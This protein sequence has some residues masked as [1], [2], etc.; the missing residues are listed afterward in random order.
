MRIDSSLILPAF[1]IDFVHF[2]ENCRNVVG[3]F[4]AWIMRLEFAVVTDPP[5][6]VPG[7]VLLLI[8]VRQTLPGDLFAQSDPFEHGAVA[9]AAPTNIIDFSNSG[10][11]EKLIERL[12]QIAAVDGIADLLAFVPENRVR[13]AGHDAAHQIAQKPVQLGGGVLRSG[14]RSPPEAG[15]AQAEVPSILLNENI[16]RDFRR[17]E[18]AVQA[19]VDRHILSD[20]RLVR[21]PRRDLIAQLPLHQRQAVGG[22]PINF[23]GRGENKDCLGAVLPGRFQKIERP[24]GVYIKIGERLPGRPVMRWLRRRVNNQGDIFAVAG[25]DRLDRVPVPDIGCE[26]RVACAQ[27]GLEV[28]DIPGRAGFRAEEDLTHIVVYP[29]DIQPRL[30]EMQRRFRTDQSG[31][32]GDNCNAHSVFLF[33]VLSC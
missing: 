7:P 24:G 21:M 4:P 13:C 3:L 6:V 32:A 16:G 22:I 27:L 25:K 8:R 14:E 15:A 20:A 1:L 18:Q 31:G 26:M 23:V 2:C 19:L 5:E 12:N 28:F 29:D 10:A 30:P 33:R 17:P 9:E 11:A